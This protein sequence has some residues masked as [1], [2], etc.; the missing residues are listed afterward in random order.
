MLAE[1]GQ[2]ENARE[3]LTQI[4][5]ASSSTTIS[6]NLA[7]VLIELGQAKAGISIVSRYPLNMGYDA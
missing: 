5:E 4:M 3:V 7:H 6:I 1:S 2:L